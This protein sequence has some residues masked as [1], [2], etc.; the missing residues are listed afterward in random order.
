MDFGPDP[1]AGA[2]KDILEKL[3]ERRARARAGGGERASRRSTSAA[4]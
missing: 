1:K 3:E 4:S 2:M